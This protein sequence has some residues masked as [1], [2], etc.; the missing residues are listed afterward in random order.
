[1]KKVMLADDEDGVLALVA[2]T[3]GNDSRYSLLTARD[4]EEALALARK[5]L[6]DLVFLDV[7]MPKMD[8]YAVC[9]A[10]KRSPNT[11]HIKVVML[12]AMAQDANRER[13]RAVGA[14]GYFTKPFSPTSLLE[15]VSDLLGLK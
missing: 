1:M 4:G 9:Q 11:R 13:A 14:D 15:K 2:A 12:T 8:G 3:L 7:M 5:E 10:L 6:P